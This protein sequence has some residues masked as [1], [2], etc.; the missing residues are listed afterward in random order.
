MEPLK[1]ETWLEEV[2]HEGHK[3]QEGQ[4]FESYRLVLTC[5]VL[6]HHEVST[7]PCAPNTSH[8]EDYQHVGHRM[9]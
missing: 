9:G 6:I 1:D 3:G 2:G 8:R 7:L 5:C 4:A